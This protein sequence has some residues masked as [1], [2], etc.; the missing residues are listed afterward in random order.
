MNKLRTAGFGVLLTVLYAAQGCSN[1]SEEPKQKDHVFKGYEQALDKA[2]QVQTQLDE[3][4]E[5]RRKQMEEMT[6]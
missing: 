3:A 4:E 1:G 6:R 5:K 2:K